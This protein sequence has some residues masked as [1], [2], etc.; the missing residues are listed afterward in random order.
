MQTIY[1][2]SS[3]LNSTNTFLVGFLLSFLIWIGCSSNNFTT[4]TFFSIIGGCDGG[5]LLAPAPFFI[6]GGAIFNLSASILAKLPPIILFCPPNL[7]PPIAGF[8]SFSFFSFS[9]LSLSSLSFLSLSFL[10]LSSLS[11]LSLSFLSLSSLSFLSLSSL[12][13]LSLSSLSF[14]SFSSLSFLSFSSLS[15]CSLKISSLL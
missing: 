11:F 4:S 14:L 1:S 12:S 10:S 8:F 15:L 2:Y 9:F 6:P 7:G 3:S 5:S 13:L